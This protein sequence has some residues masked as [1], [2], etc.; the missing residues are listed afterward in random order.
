[1][2]Y[3]R[4][5]WDLRGRLHLTLWRVPVAE[6][7]AL[8]AELRP[9]QVGASALVGTAW[10]IYQPGGVLHYRELLAAVLVRHRHAPRL[11][12]TDIWVDSEPALR[13]G[14]ELWG[15]PKEPAT[16]QLAGGDLSAS[17][18]EG[19]PIARGRVTPVA[20]L[21]G[22]WPA[23]CT[24]AQQLAGTMAQTP[25]HSTARLQLT[26]ASWDF[27]PDGPLGWLVGARALVS[28][29]LQDFRLRFGAP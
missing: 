11:S 16:F 21:P 15:I 17:T 8:P 12:I 10:V 18:P 28:V 22:R 20:A 7:P 9:V 23:R 19:S 29:S 27:P 2:I 26:R 25:V 4:A 1:M 24:V 6:L 14:R 13:G 3:P 5:P